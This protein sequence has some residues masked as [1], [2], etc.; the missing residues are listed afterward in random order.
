MEN[1]TSLDQEKENQ[2]PG[3]A[4]RLWQGESKAS[5]Q[6]PGPPSPE[7]RK[8]EQRLDTETSPRMSPSW[9]HQSR[10]SLSL[11]DLTAGP[12]V[13]SSPPPPP[14][15][16][17]STSLNTATT[18]DPV[19]ASHAERSPNGITDTGTPYSDPWESS[20]A[21]RQ[22]TS[23][24]TSHAEESTLPQSQTPHPDLC[25]LR[26]ASRNKSKH[27]GLRFDLLQE[28]DSN[29]SCD[30]D[31]PEVGASDAAQ[32]MLEVA[33]QNAKAYLLSTSSKSGLNL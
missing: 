4:E 32:N 30:P 28:D 12:E 15:E 21:A 9:S 10:A 2:E 23:H 25:G 3:E 1:S 5:P 16:F 7:Y 26:D 13:S 29:S 33:I 27:K 11:E 17:H 18:Q 8:E 24:Y 31:Q 22:S 19:G 6:D 20:S 14:L